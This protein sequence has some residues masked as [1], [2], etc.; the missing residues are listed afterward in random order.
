MSD[1][2]RLSL[3]LYI[4]VEEEHIGTAKIHPVQRNLPGVVLVEVGDIF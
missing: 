1:C 4:Y 3:S 2:P